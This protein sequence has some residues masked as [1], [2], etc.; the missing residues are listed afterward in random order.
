M[1]TSNII[2]IPLDLYNYAKLTQHFYVP[3]KRYSGFEETEKQNRG[4]G[5]L[6]DLIGSLMVYQLLANQNRI[7]R[8]QLCSGVG[9]KSDL[10]VSID[11]KIKTI[12]IKTSMYEPYREGLRLFIKEEEISKSID[13]YMQV[14][15]H[16]TEEGY[17]PHIHIGGWIPKES[18]RWKEYNEIMVIPNTGGHR[19][20]GI[21]VERLAPLDFLIKKADVKF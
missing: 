18:P 3:L 14:F 13:I 15:V 16:L 7:C 10:D 12:N 6:T 1:F 5:D 19:G 20:M 17:P 8:L 11:G 9:D 2:E 4:D 21:P